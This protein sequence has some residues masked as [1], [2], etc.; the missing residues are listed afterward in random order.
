MNVLVTCGTGAIGPSVVN[1][2]LERGHT[3]RLLSRH[4]EHD[5][6]TWPGSI[7]T[8]EGDVIDPPSLEGTA[9]GADVVVHLAGIIE[10]AP[11]DATFQRVNVEGTRN[12]VREAER[13]GVP[14]IVCVSSL[15]SMRG[16]S[17]HHR[18]KRD[19]EAIVR[20]FSGAWIIL[21]PGAVYGPGDEHIS[22][23][24]KM[25]RTL[26]AVPLI[27]DGGQLFQ[28]IWHEDAAEAIAQAVERDDLDGGEYDIA[29]DDITSQR[30]L[31][32]RLQRLTNRAT[33]ALP[34]PELLAQV[35]LKAAA[36][37]GVDVGFSE[38]QLQMLIEGNVLPADADNALTRVFDVTPMPLEKGLRLLADNQPELLPDRGIGPLTRKRYWT[39]IRGTTLDAD[40]LL[41]HVRA[42]FRVL[43]PEI[44][45]TSA[46]P[47]TPTC[48]EEGATLTLSIPLRGHVQLR[49]AE[50][51][52]R[53]FTLLTVAGHPL[54]GAV[55]VQ[56]EP[57]GDAIRFEV[58]TYER[59][60]SIP[61]LVLMR[62]LGGSLQDRAWT[63]L[64]QN[65]V[66][67][68][69]GR[70]DEVQRS[71]ESLAGSEAAVVQRWAE[72]LVVLRKQREVDL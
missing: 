10:E 49:V 18:S 67:D 27:G 57:I 12:I 9:D 44:M 14:K 55:R 58:Q 16:Q 2:L 21:R 6:R 35:G 17:P 51:D 52:D 71:S 54:A 19:A 72:E 53:R 47:G 22:S 50:V 70:A 43:A 33:V 37:A 15:G 20:A 42:R 40:R 64:I 29:G 24:L 45:S 1:A 7:N 32:A 41:D 69:G 59:P 25:V 28:P 48:I 68:T 65:V 63:H 61:D 5:S 31:L 4:A 13:A 62:T 39:D 30:D 66:R 26:P 34:V 60:A 8:V 23:L 46:E 38:S 3:V 56:T 11:P 36:L